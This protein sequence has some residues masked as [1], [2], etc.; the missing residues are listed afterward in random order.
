M[1]GPGQEVIEMSK[2]NRFKA[3]IAAALAISALAAS[4]PAT[5]YAQPVGGVLMMTVEPG[6]GGH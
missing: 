4:A 6:G 3:A 2:R 5:R 1:L